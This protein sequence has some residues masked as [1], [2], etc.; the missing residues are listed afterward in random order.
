MLLVGAHAA[1]ASSVL[2]KSTSAIDSLVMARLARAPTYER[3]S[4]N[5]LLTAS[6]GLD[7]SLC[8]A[9][10]ANI[11]HDHCAELAKQEILRR[12]PV[13]ELLAAVREAVMVNGKGAEAIQILEEIKGPGVEA[14]LRSIAEPFTTDPGNYLALL[15]FADMCQTWSLR[16][17][18]RHW[19]EW[20]ISS[21]LW[22][23]AVTD[24]GRCEYRPATVNLISDL[25]AASG[26]LID[27][28]YDS[29]RRMYPDG[30]KVSFGEAAVK[31]WT[32]WI[33][34]HAKS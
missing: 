3:F 25:D 15:H 18:N 20:G 26:N 19:F 32:V 31:A 5:D 13:K 12:K 34:A 1:Y 11:S 23:Q 17:L 22:A 8:A 30:P 6:V 24:F 28:A 27:A 2:S 10:G 16:V 7:A 29:L 4:N 33:D 21:V 9:S 14:G